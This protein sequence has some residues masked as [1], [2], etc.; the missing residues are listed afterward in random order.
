MDEYEETRLKR[1]RSCLCCCF[2]PRYT[3]C[4]GDRLVNFLVYDF[5]CFLITVG[6][7]AYYIF[8]LNRL[9]NEYQIKQSIIFVQVIYGLLNIPFVIFAAKPC[10]LFLSKSRETAYD[11]DGNCVPKYLAS[12]M[13]KFRFGKKRL[14]INSK[15][16]SLKVD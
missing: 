3:C 9:D 15:G 8:G 14:I 2:C 4:T 11:R 6:Y 13:Y 1:K 10:V 7:L 16:I 5:F 12:N